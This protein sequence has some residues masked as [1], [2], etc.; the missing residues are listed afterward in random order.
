MAAADSA[1]LDVCTDKIIDS[2]CNLDLTSWMVALIRSQNLTATFLKGM[3]DEILLL[4]HLALK[5]S[6]LVLF[7]LNLYLVLIPEPILNTSP[8]LT[9]N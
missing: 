2:A 7:L 4:L 6:D 5:H 1:L 8:L 9:F 3:T